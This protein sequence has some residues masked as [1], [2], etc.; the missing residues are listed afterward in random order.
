ME[1]KT[2]IPKFDKTLGGLDLISSQH[3]SL[4]QAFHSSATGNI[5][6]F[7]G[8]PSIFHVSLSGHRPVPLPEL[9]PFPFFTSFYTLEIRWPFYLKI[10]WFTSTNWVALTSVPSAHLAWS[11]ER[12][13]LVHILLHFI[14]LPIYFT[15]WSVI[16]SEVRFMFYFISP[17]LSKMSG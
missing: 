17:E 6:W 8:G 10:P 13:A 16:L 15:S 9:L 14:C 1:D 11:Q 2:V 5:S 7:H 4:P 12:I 3:L